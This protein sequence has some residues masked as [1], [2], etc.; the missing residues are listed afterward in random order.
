MNITV[1][2]EVIC[3]EGGS[4]ELLLKQRE[5]NIKTTIVEL[6]GNIV[7]SSDFAITELTDGDILELV[8][9]VGG[10]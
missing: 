8:Q 1:N 5:N 3:F 7:P 9:F 6:N 4:I 10:G 2:G